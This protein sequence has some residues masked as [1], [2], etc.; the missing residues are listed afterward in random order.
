MNC[1]K[2]NSDLFYFEK[3][4][5]SDGSIHL[6]RHCASCRTFQKWEKHSDNTT[7]KEDYIKEHM[8]N[9]EATEKQI[10]YIRDVIKYKGVIGSKLHAS[11]LISDYKKK[12]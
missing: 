7:S 3:R 2:C 11:N 5:F 8:S 9:H 1:K 4:V 10:K 12:K 6:A